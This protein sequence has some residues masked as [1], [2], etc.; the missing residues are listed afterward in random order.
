MTRYASWQLLS[1]GSSQ[2]FV[3]ALRREALEHPAVHH[4][5]LRRLSTGDFPN[6]PWAIRDYAF[7]YS[8]YGQDFT[9]YL[10]GVIGGLASL[11]HR[12]VI[13]Q[14]LEEEKGDPSSDDLNRMPHTRLFQL[15]RR[16]AG[17]TEEFEAITQ[18]CTT[19][20]VWRDLF[21]QKCHSRQPGVALGGIGLGT[22]FVVPTIYSYI[23]QGIRDH[24]SISDRDSYF[25]E[26]HAKCD[27]KHA[28]LL[29]D[30]TTELSE[31]RRNTREAIR[32]GVNSALNLRCAFW[33]VMM[34]RAIG[35]NRD[36]KVEP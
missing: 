8:F 24:T 34:A 21:L 13:R 6:L 33:D 23:H 36:D 11:H 30:I 35:A 32:F 3:D 5:Y 26:L 7:Q 17:V 10:E 27:D 19:V 16:A 20:L 15:F 4:P 9:N 28:Q 12:E 18:P 2:E 31:D 14:N 22:E 25:F 29:I 1:Q